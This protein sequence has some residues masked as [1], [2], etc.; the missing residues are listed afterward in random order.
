MKIT[1]VNIPANVV[2]QYQHIINQWIM[3]VRREG[4][5]KYLAL[6]GLL[7]LVFPE[8]S[9]DVVE[10]EI[11]FVGLNASMVYPS[12]DMIVSPADNISKERIER[13]SLALRQIWEDLKE[14]TVEAA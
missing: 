12:G 3:N 4:H 14:S 1:Y 11:E 8:K 10:T 6:D 5:Q 7:P 2:W 9:T 13:H